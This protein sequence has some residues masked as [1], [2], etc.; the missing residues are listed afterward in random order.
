VGHKKRKSQS[1]CSINYSK[2]RKEP[3]HIGKNLIIHVIHWKEYN[4]QAW[5]LYD[6]T[7]RKTH[8]TTLY[9]NF[10]T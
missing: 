8:I 2:N 10:T 5:I 9:F 4:N 7:K 1:S 3:N 6:S